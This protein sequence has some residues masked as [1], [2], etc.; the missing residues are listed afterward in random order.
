MSV[1]LCGQCYLQGYCRRLQSRIIADAELTPAFVRDVRAH[2]RGLGIGADR[3]A[4]FLIEAY[5][6]YPGRIIDAAGKEAMLDTAV[7]DTPNIRYWFRDLCRPLPPGVRPRLKQAARERFR[8]AAS[9]L[10]ALHPVPALL[11]GREIANDADAAL[12]VLIR[13]GE[14]PYPHFHMG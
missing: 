2:M 1:S 12:P 14:C 4:S 13:A 3:W 10:R 11:W 6:D 9:I 8:V 5:R 7:L